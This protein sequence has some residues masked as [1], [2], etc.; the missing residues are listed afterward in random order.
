[1]RRAVAGVAAAV[2]ALFGSAAASAAVP[3]DIQFQAFSPSPV[4]VLPGEAVEWTNVSERRHTVTADNGSF[5][6]GD[7]FGGDQFEVTYGEV[8]SFPYHCRVH[9]GMTGEVD[10]RRVT[11]GPL[12]TDLVPAGKEVEMEGR[13]ADPASPVEIQRS[14]GGEFET[15][16]T[17][18]PDG[19]GAWVADVVAEKTAQYRAAVGADA[20]E[21][22]R[23]LVSDRRVIVRARP[24]RV[25]VRVVPPAP[26]GRV[27]LEL[28]LHD[29]FGWWP[30]QRRRLDYLSEATF[31]VDRRVRA[32]VALVDSDRW[33]AIARS[34]VVRLRHARRR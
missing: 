7:V 34:R 32:R 15:V 23:L 33:T 16:A 18:T 1:M 25:S 19:D 12:P 29:R 26:Y 5:D 31:R 28:R 11:L 2:A 27:N 30:A 20:S 24:G 6:S 3:V 13:A 9:P 21:V 10:V 22:R 4:D 17:A 14:T 8:G